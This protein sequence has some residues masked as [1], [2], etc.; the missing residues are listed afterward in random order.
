M[1]P[2][3]PSAHA[4]L[5]SSSPR[6]SVSTMYKLSCSPGSSANATRASTPTSTR[7]S[8]PSSV[9][10][11]QRKLHRLEADLITNQ[12]EARDAQHD[13]QQ[14]LEDKDQQVNDLQH[15][16]DELNEKL[17]ER[18]TTIAELTSGPGRGR[19]ANV[20][21]HFQQL[22]HDVGVFGTSQ[23]VRSDPPLRK[24]P[25][26]R[27]AP[28]RVL[29]LQSPPPLLCLPVWTPVLSSSDTAEP[30]NAV[31]ADPFTSSICSF[32]PRRRS[33]YVR[34]TGDTKEALGRCTWP[35]HRE[36]L[37]SRLR[38]HLGV[39]VHSPGLEAILRHTFFLSF[40]PHRGK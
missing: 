17:S 30:S 6:C 33:S 38:R 1:R 14:L 3:Q 11:E 31:F 7:R 8:S 35:A 24:S 15:E 4:L 34:R 23:N 39:S 18:N 37:P 21:E 22:K 28:P 2:T 20:A 13:L 29:P 27:P 40:A 9:A 16:Q 36:G 12:A 10:D 26:L 19:A 25:H 5:S 32:I